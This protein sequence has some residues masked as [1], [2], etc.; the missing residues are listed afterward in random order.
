MK[1][2]YKVNEQ[3]NIAELIDLLLSGNSFNKKIVVRS[4]F[5]EH[6]KADVM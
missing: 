1:N 2:A 3:P 6:Y 5:T 4:A